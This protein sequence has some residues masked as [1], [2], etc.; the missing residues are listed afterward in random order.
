M[1]GKTKFVLNC[2][3]YQGLYSEGLVE[4]GLRGILKRI[5]E[6]KNEGFK[7]GGG[8]EKESLIEIVNFL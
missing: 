8:L 1:R 6:K 3:F 2:L 7:D 4:V 5:R